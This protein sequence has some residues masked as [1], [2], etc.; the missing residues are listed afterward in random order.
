MPKLSL[1]RITFWSAATIFLFAG[2][3]FRY[4][5]IPVAR[6]FYQHPMANWQ[7]FSEVFAWLFLPK[8]W[9]VFGVLGCITSWL[10]RR[11][12]K[13]GLAKQVLFFGL[14]IVISYALT[15]ILKTFLGRLRP[16]YYFQ[17]GL[18]G[19]QILSFKTISPSMPSGH[20]TVS[21]AV[22]IALASIIRK[23]WV[24]VLLVALA[25]TSAICRLILLKH[26]VSDVV[27]GAYLATMVV[28]WVRHFL[29][30]SKA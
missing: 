16:P 10:L 23:R 5:D 15:T 11:S 30:L 25:I 4:I 28:F 7:A 8:I 24:S 6:W 13:A 3:S 2:L 12:G 9:F 1:S 26:Y 22:C 14:T 17:H 18:Y 29:L 21:F 20:A 27:V 19:F